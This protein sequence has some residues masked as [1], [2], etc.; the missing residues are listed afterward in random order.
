LKQLPV[1][2][3]LE[4]M[5]GTWSTADNL[6]IASTKTMKTMEIDDGKQV[7][8]V[9]TDNPTVMQAFHQK[10]YLWVLVS[11]VFPADF[12]VYLYVNNPDIPMFPP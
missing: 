11:V 3:T 9:T 7:I 2:L 12:V 6:L 1:V 8:A 10:F 4:D 5:T